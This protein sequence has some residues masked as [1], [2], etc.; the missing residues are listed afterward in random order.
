RLRVRCPV[1]CAVDEIDVLDDPGQPARVTGRTRDLLDV[2]EV[3]RVVSVVVAAEE[4]DG[5]DLGLA[6][7][8][9]AQFVLGHRRILEHLV[10]PR[11]RARFRGYPGGDSTHMVYQ[12]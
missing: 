2:R 10:Q 8:R 12:G 1:C 5:A 4:T 7:A 6:C 11:D 9:G 3:G